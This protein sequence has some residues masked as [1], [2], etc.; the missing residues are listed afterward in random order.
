M[1]NLRQLHPRVMKHF[2]E[3]WQFGCNFGTRSDFL[4][5]AMYIPWY[6]QPSSCCTKNPISTLCAPNA[7]YEVYTCSLRWY[8][9]GPFCFLFQLLTL[10]S[11][12]NYC[13]EFDNAGAVMRVT[14]DL[15]CSFKILEVFTIDYINPLH[16]C[17]MIEGFTFKYQ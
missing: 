13:G 16:F 11:A 9:N 12:P 2:R 17:F 14:D 6:S 5:V 10:F 7:T 8:E 15:T 1:T 3:I 4:Y